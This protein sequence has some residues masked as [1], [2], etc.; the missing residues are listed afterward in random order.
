MLALPQSRQRHV[1]GRHRDERHLRLE[2]EIAGRCAVDDDQDGWPDIVVANDTQPNK[3]YR[4][5]R[6]G[7]FKEVAFEAGV[8]FSAEGRAR[9]GMGVDAADFDNSGRMGIAVTNF[10]NEMTGLYRSQGKG[11]YQDVAAEGWCRRRVKEWLG[12][13][14]GFAD[15]DLDG[16]LDLVTPTA[17]STRPFAAFASASATRSRRFSFRTSA[18][19]RFQDIAAA[20]GAVSRAPEWAVVSRSATSIVTATSTC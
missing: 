13:G 6:N 12:F 7:T 14:C 20:A 2:L 3:L 15:L 8:A 10:E 5:L 19:A 18:T 1:R 11:L 16:M 4:N 17:T 9:A